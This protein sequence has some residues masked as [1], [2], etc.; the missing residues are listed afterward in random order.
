[1]NKSWQVAGIEFDR[2]QFILI[3]LDKVFFRL[4]S[5]VMPFGSESPGFRVRFFEPGLF[6]IEFEGVFVILKG[7]L[8]V[9]DFIET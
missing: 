1:V 6:S 2:G 3:V 7:F 5:R 9:T 8:K 4:F